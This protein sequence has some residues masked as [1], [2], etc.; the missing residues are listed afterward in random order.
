MKCGYVDGE[1]KDM[2]L[3][4]ELSTDNTA[5]ATA[6]VV[7]ATPLTGADMIEVGYL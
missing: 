1:C 5:T 3:P 6:V 7:E 4:R 2:S